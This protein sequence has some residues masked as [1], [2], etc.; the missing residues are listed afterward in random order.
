MSRLK[1][2]LQ[3][4]G[5]SQIEL[6]IVI[7]IIMILVS[8]TTPTVGNMLKKHTLVGSSNVL[9]ADLNF[10]R[11]TAIAHSSRT[12]ICPVQNVTLDELQ[13]AKTNNWVNGWIIFVDQNRNL[14]IDNQEKILRVGHMDQ[15][16]TAN[17]A[18]RRYFRFDT[19]GMALGLPGSIYICRKDKSNNGHRIVISNV[20]RI[21]SEPAGNR[22]R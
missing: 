1:P 7:S 12:I 3:Q 9:F 2:T 22:C 17:S 21:R 10:A 4:I 8:I 15:N 11:Q 5:L 19:T 20:G 18:G 13:C 6:M 14:I 16:L